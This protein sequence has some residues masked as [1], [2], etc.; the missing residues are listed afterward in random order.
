MNRN[1]AIVLVLLAGALAVA[2]GLR[3]SGGGSGEGPGAEAAAKSDPRARV[4]REVSITPAE[5]AKRL[6]AL[7]STALGD[8]P[9]FDLVD[10][11]TEKLTREDLMSMIEADRFDSYT[12]LDGW[13]RCALFAEFGRRDPNAAIAFLRNYPQTDETQGYAIQQSWY[14]LLRGMAERDPHG[15]LAAL[16]KH[17]EYGIR[18]VAVRHATRA[19]YRELARADPD[20]AWR[21]V[22]GGERGLLDPVAVSGF[23]EGL[24]DADEAQRFISNWSGRHWE[25]EEAAARYD[26]HARATSASGIRSGAVALLPIET[27]ASDAGPAWARHDVEAAIAWLDNHGPGTDQAREWRAIR[28]LEDYAVQNPEEAMRYLAEDVENPRHMT[29]LA[30]G[31]IASDSSLGPEALGHVPDRAAR[32]SALLV[33]VSQGG[34]HHVNDFFPAPGRH[35]P[36]RDFEQRYHD[37]LALIDSGDFGDHQSQSM[38]RRLH[39][40]FRH[41]VAAAREAHEALQNR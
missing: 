20:T 18:L 39:Q 28:M 30:I 35:N 13:L 5:A 24:L 14:S 3:G 4:R 2:I 33:A 31:L 8:A 17:E 34:S 29:Q 26:E 16:E 40:T 25:S 1:I 41:Q 11:W 32:I 15:A 27:I 36:L 38:R 21:M 23:F 37:L 9:P 19:I 10:A 6:R 12:G 7:P 22:G